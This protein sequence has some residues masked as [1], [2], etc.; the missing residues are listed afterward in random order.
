MAKLGTWDTFDCPTTNESEAYAWLQTEL[1][2][3]G[4]RVRLVQNPHDFGMYPS[5]E[6]DTPDWYDHYD[7]TELNE[8]EE[9]SEEQEELW[10]KYD[11]W[12]YAINDVYTRFCNKYHND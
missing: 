7:W 3:I 1:E 6:V 2:K 4:G 5:F 11:K 8:A 9:L 12:I 10:S